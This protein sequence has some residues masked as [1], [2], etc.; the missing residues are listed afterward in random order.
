MARALRAASRL[1]KKTKVLFLT[2]L[3]LF[4]CLVTVSRTT[5]TTVVSC[6]LQLVRNVISVHWDS[7]AWGRKVI[8]GR[9]S[10]LDEILEQLPGGCRAAGGPEVSGTLQ[11]PAV[12]DDVQ[13]GVHDTSSLCRSQSRV[14]CCKLFRR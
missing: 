4:A 5:S 1:S 7:S 12:S 11:R 9:W 2:L 3:S 8:R 14:F 10:T 6:L 13:R